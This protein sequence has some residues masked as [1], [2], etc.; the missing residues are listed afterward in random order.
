MRR[1]RSATSLVWA[2]G[3]VGLVALQLT[4]AVVSDRPVGSPLG[5]FWLVVTAASGC[6]LTAVWLLARAVRD[7]AAESGFLGGFAYTVSVLP[8]VHGL[9][10]PG[11]LYGPNDAVMTSVLWAVPL[12]VL[13]A[14]P[15]LLPRRWH[16]LTRRWRWWVG[17][18]L[19][20]D[21]ALAVALLVEPSLLPPAAFGEAFPT[22]LAIVGLAGA[23]AIS[24]RHVR[25]ARV[26]HR[27]AVLL[28]SLSIASIA[29]GNLVWVNGTPMTIGFWLAHGLD[30][31]G[32]FAVTIVAAMS[33]RRHGVEVD[34]FRPLTLRDPLDALEYGLDPVVRAFV[35]DLGRKDPITREHVKRVAEAAIRLA[36]ELR[37]DPDELR[38]AGL[39]ALLHDV[40][41]L[42]IPDAILAK[43]GR[44]T[45]DEFAIV[46]THARIGA[47]M[48]AGS[49]VL[50]GVAPVIR[51]HHERVDGAG[52]PD[53]LAGQEIPLLA[54]VVSVCDAWDAM[55]HTRQYREGMDD[56][57]AR[58]ILREHA[59]SQWDGD[60]V[61]A[62]LAVLE[63]GEIATEPTTLA[64]LGTEG[65]GCSCLVALPPSPVPA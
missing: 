11:V 5:L 41:K 55:V 32:V 3:W 1:G 42:E 35:A 10:V 19:V 21:T 7:D 28:V 8:L 2:A 46:Q 61:A 39:G 37:L 24:A 64:E 9:T 44:L 26:S 25:L 49:P 4:S 59:G 56:D 14:A 18:N 22:G 52:Y 16:R 40:G 20:V 34:V 43:P 51:H 47:E 12:A 65:V 29:A 36:E 38:I 13:S 45:K 15:L 63:S 6:V 27:P 62:F 23:V 31:V 53:G 58:S 60:V 17:A 33:Y 48:V 30:I 54:R 50:D 57:I